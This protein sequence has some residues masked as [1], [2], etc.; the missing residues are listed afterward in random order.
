MT[1]F[2]VGLNWP[3]KSQLGWWPMAKI[4]EALGHG[5]RAGDAAVGRI[6][7]EGR[8]GT[9]GQQVREETG[10]VWTPIWGLGWEMLT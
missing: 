6:P 8:H 3:D 4:G 7:S 10:E 5:A 9:V 1:L 2:M